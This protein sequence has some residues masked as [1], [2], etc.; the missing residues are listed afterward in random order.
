[1]IEALLLSSTF[2]VI[3]LVAILV[4]AISV[5]R[6]AADRERDNQKRFEELTKRIDETQNLFRTQ[7]AD[8]LDNFKNL[9]K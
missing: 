3:I 8:I 4:L 7:V 2:M 6:W 1:M 9:L 5:K